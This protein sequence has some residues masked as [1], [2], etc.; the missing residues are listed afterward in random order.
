MVSNNASAA[1]REGF[2]SKNNCLPPRGIEREQAEAMREEW[3]KN[4]VPV[5]Q[6]IV[7]LVDTPEKEA[8]TLKALDEA[9]SAAWVASSGVDEHIVDPRGLN[10]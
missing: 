10:E 2:P 5:E 3:L 7:L 4:G 9:F 6:N 8:E 1:R